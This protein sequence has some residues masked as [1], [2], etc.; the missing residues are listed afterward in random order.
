MDV[1]L[2]GPELFNWQVEIKR[3]KL[4]HDTGLYIVNNAVLI[5]MALEGGHC[6]H[7]KLVGGGGG[8]GGG[9]CPWYPL[10]PHQ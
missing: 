3:R 4:I 10:L 5:N 6:P 2:I 1:Q 7:F 9:T 8:G